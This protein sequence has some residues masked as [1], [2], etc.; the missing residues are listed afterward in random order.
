MPE[1]L[2]IVLV[3]VISVGIYIAALVRSRDP[4]LH[5]PTRERVRAEQQVV[6][7]E[8]RLAQ[9]RREGWGADM[10]SELENRIAE[11]RP[12]GK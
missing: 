8:E 4:A 2:A 7:L 1:A 11:A 3:F 5:E 9:A 10:L 6:W 12:A